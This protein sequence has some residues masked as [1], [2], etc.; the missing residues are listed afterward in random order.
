ME[1]GRSRTPSSATSR[2]EMR[3]SRGG[4]T[5]SV[6]ALP[7]PSTRPS[8]GARGSW[9][10]RVA[11][12]AAL[13]AAT[14]VVPVQDELNGRAEAVE[15][16]SDLVGYPTAFEV[17]SGGPV[18]D[19]PTSLLAAMPGTVRVSDTA[20][21][22]LDRSPL[23]DCDGV[24]VDNVVNGQIAA[25]D[26]CTLW[27]PGHMLRADAAVALA[28]LNLTFRAAFDRDLCLTDS[29]RTLADQRRLARTKGWLAA[30]PGVSNHGWGLAV[31]LCHSETQNRSVMS[32][33]ED[34][35]AVYGWHNPPWARRGGSGPYE[36]WHWEYL[37]GT[38]EM[39]SNWD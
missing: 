30:P 28:E 27:V 13:G 22:A 21:R 3:A 26:L 2:R 38:V 25:A 23:P 32:W 7:G 9:V 15:A 5:G 34:N 8:A 14:I 24:P 29:Y 6:P 39:G 33:L 4:T 17:L 35:G 37:Q 36:P 20:S 31:D 10:A 16:A 1:S 19:T 11:V 18:V 12:L